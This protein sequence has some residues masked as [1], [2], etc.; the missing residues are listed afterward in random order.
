MDTHTQQ[1]I[2]MQEVVLV[3]FFL[4]SV[5]PLAGRLSA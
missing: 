5:S 3:H 4:A 2:S 1:K